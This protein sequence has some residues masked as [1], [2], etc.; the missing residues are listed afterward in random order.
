[1]AKKSKSARR[2]AQNRRPP[3]RPRPVATTTPTAGET[4]ASASA[5]TGQG[6]LAPSPEATDVG[7]DEPGAGTAPATMPAGGPAARPAPVPGAGAGLRRVGRVDPALRPAG[8]GP[9]PGSQAAAFEPLDPED[10]AI[11]YDRVPYVPG[12]LRR[13]GVMAA[14]MVVLIVVAAIVV[15][16]VVK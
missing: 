8:R 1:M 2:A 9:R 7:L 6:T 15:N 3:V 5:E 12:D 4:A 14:A 16:A 11:P 13:V 10:A